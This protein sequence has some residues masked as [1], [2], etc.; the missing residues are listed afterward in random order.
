MTSH[1]CSDS[2]WDVSSFYKGHSSLLICVSSLLS[3]FN[4][5][6]MWKPAVTRYRSSYQL[7]MNFRYPIPWNCLY[8]IHTVALG[9]V[10]QHRVQ[11]MAVMCELW[12][13]TWCLLGL[14]LLL[15][16]TGDENATSMLRVWDNNRETT[17]Q[18]LSQK[19]RLHFGKL[20]FFAS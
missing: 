10:C 4:L 18:F 11:H 9:L 20:S 17:H 3:L 13:A 8:F 1:S 5:S 2:Q 19:N 14:G 16:R 6:P 7:S 15:G 12:L